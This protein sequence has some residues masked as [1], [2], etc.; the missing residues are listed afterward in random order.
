MIHSREKSTD[1]IFEF[2]DIYNTFEKRK[3]LVCVPSSY[4]QVFER[5]LSERGSQ[6]NNLCKSSFK[7]CLSF[8]AQY[9][10]FHIKEWKIIR[11]R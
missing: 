7:K 10:N 8:N 4:N 9:S 2:I 5:E 6:Y 1:E 3:P 11:M